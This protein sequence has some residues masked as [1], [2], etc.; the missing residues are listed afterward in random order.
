MPAFV[1]LRLTMGDTKIGS[2]S[3]RSAAVF[4]HRVNSLPRLRVGALLLCLL[5]TASHGQAVGPADQIDDEYLWAE[6]EGKRQFDVELSIKTK[7]YF[8]GLLPSTSPVISASAGWAWPSG[9]FVGAYGGV[10]LNDKTSFN[11]DGAT[12]TTGHYQETDLFAG[13]HTPRYT[14][15]LDYYYNYTEGISDV[16]KPGG[17][18]DFDKQSA[19][20]LLDLIF[21]YRFGANREWQIESST[22]LGGLRDVDTELRGDP[23]VSVRTDARYSQ[24]MELQYTKTMKSQ[25]LDKLKVRVG[26]AWRWTNDLDGPNFYAG[27][28]SLVNVSA[29][30]IKYFSFGEKGKIPLKVTLAWNPDS[31]NVYLIASVSLVQFA[32][33]PL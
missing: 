33:I 16:P 27:S 10:G 8:R 2:S 20:G 13:L 19:R 28:A 30:Y 12:T 1:E 15:I 18:F 7:N 14:V 6:S 9:W 25:G 23:P 29:D 22:L 31:D 5:A 11:D 32:N 3:N 24:Y 4:F 26:G 17:F 21:Q